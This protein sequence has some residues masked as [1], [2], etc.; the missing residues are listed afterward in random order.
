[1]SQWVL[2]ERLGYDLWLVR[3]H[4]SHKSP[5]NYSTLDYFEE[6]QVTINSPIKP[7]GLMVGL[8]VGQRQISLSGRSICPMALA[9]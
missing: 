6:Y 1:M 9:G 7:I 8:G 2:K 3:Y 5:C 4:D